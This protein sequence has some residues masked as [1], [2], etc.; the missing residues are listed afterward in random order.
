MSLGSILRS[1]QDFTDRLCIVDKKSNLVKFGSVKTVEQRKLIDMLD[2][3]KRVAI[4]KA[5]QLGATTA[6]RSHCF[7]E[8]YTSPK[9]VRSACISNKSRSAEALL[10]MDRTFYKNLPGKL[11]RPMSDDKAMGYSYSSTGAG[12]LAF[13]AKS[14]SQD[15]GYTFSSIHM[16]EFAFFDHAAEVLAS[17]EA[18][19]DE[20]RIIIESTPNHYGDELHNIALDSMYND[21]WKVI[22]MPWFTFPS[23]RKELPKGGFEMDAAEIALMQD[24]SLTPEQIFWRRCKIETMKSE[25]L[26]RHEYPITIEEAYSLSEANFFTEEEVGQV[27]IIECKPSYKQILSPINKE[28]AYCIG[29]D[30]AGGVGKDYSVA[31][32]VEKGSNIPTVCI[33]SNSV[34]IRKFAEDVIR[35]SEELNGCLVFFEENNHGHALKEIFN[36]LGF[37]KYQAFQTTMRSKISLYDMLRSYIHEDLLPLLDRATFTEMRNLVRS[38][39]GLAP[40]HP[41]NGHDD[42]VIALMLALRGLRDVSRPKRFIDPRIRDLQRAKRSS[43]QLTNPL[44]NNRR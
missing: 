22:M 32:G 13:S 35:L 3:H 28:S 43:Q 37:N 20:G 6:V 5:R 26:F 2:S 24:C 1:S 21:S 10:R 16:S 18:T 14:D 39:K 30:T 9:P 38:E 44:F 8:V 11:K 12:A 17:W 29:V 7:H 23:Y 27:E 36:S 31:M 34:P 4:V 19:A 33:S 40:E 41:P 42:R 15:R 25:S